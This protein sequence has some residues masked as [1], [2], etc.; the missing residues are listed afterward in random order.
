MI[1]FAYLQNF[2]V[3]KPLLYRTTVSF[4]KQKKYH[5][6]LFFFDLLNFFPD[7]KI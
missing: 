4:S 6:N 5:I 1:N 2:N 3:K 7:Q